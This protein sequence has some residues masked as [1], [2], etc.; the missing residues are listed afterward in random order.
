MTID[1]LPNNPTNGRYTFSGWYTGANGSGTRFVATTPVVSNLTVYPYW[2]GG[3]SSDEDGSSSDDNDSVIA[4]PALSDRPNTP[5]QGE[6][7]VSGTVDAQGNAIVNLSDR[8]VSDAFDKALAEARG[9]GN[10]QNGIALVLRI[11]TGSNNAAHVRVNLPK[12][13]QDI[14]IAKK[15]ANTILVVDNPDI[16]IAL[17]LASVKT[18]NSQANSDV[19]LTATRMESNALTDAGKSRCERLQAEQLYRCKKRRLL[20]GV[21]RVG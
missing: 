5:T 2:T 10:E 11:D 7:K 21:Y 19:H 13:V 3:G 1:A 12:T 14:I 20:Y 15:I 8:A 16:T 4:T 9:N 17:D 18:I 6:I